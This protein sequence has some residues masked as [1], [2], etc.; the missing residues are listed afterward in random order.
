MLNIEV[1]WSN[2]LLRTV[3]VALARAV[4]VAVAKA[5]ALARAVAKAVAWPHIIKN[6]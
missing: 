1:V 3:L 2:P 4:G 6:K 5:V